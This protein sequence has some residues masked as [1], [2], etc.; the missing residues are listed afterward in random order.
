MKNPA[1]SLMLLEKKALKS[2]EITRDPI[3][4]VRNFTNPRDQ[5]FIGW[6]AAHL[7]YGRVAGIQKSIETVIQPLGNNPSDMALGASDRFWMKEY[8]SDIQDWKW[9]FHKP[10]DM[11]HWIRSWVK[12]HQSGG[13]E[14][15]LLPTKN[16]TTDEQLGLL[17]DN[18]QNDFPK[19]YGLQFN[20]TNP[21]KGSA[22]KRWRMMIRWFVR[23]GWPDV[24]IW[25]DY[26]KQD[27][28]IPVDVHIARMTRYL[29]IHDQKVINHDLAIKITNFL[30]TIDRADPLRFDYPLAH[31]GI[32]GNCPKQLDRTI[33]SICPLYEVCL[34][35]T[36]VP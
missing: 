15:R 30:K 3:R 28:I 18:L 17:I 29:G 12:I 21:R 26:P 8:L 35:P 6:I 20:L 16:L 23:S 24:G 13:L 32:D 5:E 19:T 4:F 27:L 9:R 11:I 10:A 1:V 2:R 34:R 33:C 22:A 36:W 31:M 25:R 14:Q 7:S